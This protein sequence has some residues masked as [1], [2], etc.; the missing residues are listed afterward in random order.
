M[1]KVE[2]TVVKVITM[3]CNGSQGCSIEKVILPYMI[4]KAA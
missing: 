2:T 4:V 1:K 3:N